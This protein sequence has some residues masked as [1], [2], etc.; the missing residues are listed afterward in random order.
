MAYVKITIRNTYLVF[1]ILTGLSGLFW[2]SAYCQSYNESNPQ[3]DKNAI[4]FSAGTSVLWHGASLIYERTL[5]ENLFKKNVSSFVKLGVGY[6]LMWDWLPSYG[7]PWTF[8]NYGWLVGKLNH[9]F[10]FSAGMTYSYSGD[11]SG[12]LPSGAIG[13]RYVSSE[14]KFVLR[15]NVAFPE[16][17][18]LGFGITF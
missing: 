2:S 9:Y 6:Y 7:G 8:S 13:Y 17:L 11:L 18:N 1:V 5:Q 14:G 16:A 10:E 3:Q 4:Y 15:A 12:I